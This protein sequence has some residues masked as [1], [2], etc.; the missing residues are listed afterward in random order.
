MEIVKRRLAKLDAE[1]GFIFDG[2]PRTMHQAHA[3]EEITPI[4]AVILLKVPE[5]ILLRRITSRRT[6]RECGTIYNV[7][8]LKPKVEGKC[9]KC[10]GELYQRPDEQ[11]EPTKQ[12]MKEH[13]RLTEP[14]AEFYR[15]RGLIKEIENN[16]IETPP[17]PIV[18]RILQAIGY[19]RADETDNLG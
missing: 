4:D 2:F 17:E 18:E 16:D 19:K 3:L 5:D 15:E 13:E 1:H 9:D 11:L 12:R 14:V 10:G 8:F 7:L 6:C